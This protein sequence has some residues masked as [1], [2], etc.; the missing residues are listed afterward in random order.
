MF[1]LFSPAL[2]AVWFI[3]MNRFVVTNEKFK[4]IFNYITLAVLVVVLL[5]YIDI[6]LCVVSKFGKAGGA[7]KEEWYAPFYA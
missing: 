2:V 6:F 1:A 4:H 7:W 5:C 3:Y